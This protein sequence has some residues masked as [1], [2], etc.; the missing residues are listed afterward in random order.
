MMNWFKWFVHNSIVHPIMPFLPKK[1]A[2][3]LHDKNGE[4]AFNSKQKADTEVQK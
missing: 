4:W 3:K 1:I 2:I